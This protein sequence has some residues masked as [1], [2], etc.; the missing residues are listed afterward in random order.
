MLKTS[1]FLKK[2]LILTAIFALLFLENTLP[3]LK[4]ASFLKNLPFLTI[5][6]FI[7][8]SKSPFAFF[9][10]FLGGA[11]LDFYSPLPLFSFAFL[12]L[13]IAFATKYLQ[14]MFEDNSFWGFFVSFFLSFL[15]FRFFYFFPLKSIHSY[16]SYFFRDFIFSVVLVIL[17]FLIVKYCKRFLHS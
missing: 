7:F 4:G 11:F 1:S 9:L 5:F 16:S 13:T 8:F 2:A 17:A 10:A 12:F 15:I 3:I 14:K 6:I